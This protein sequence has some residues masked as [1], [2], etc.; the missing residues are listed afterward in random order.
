MVNQR[1][2][3]VRRIAMLKLGE[4]DAMI[5]GMTRSFAQTIARGAAGA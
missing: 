3:R 5:T 4:A 2:Q 1:S